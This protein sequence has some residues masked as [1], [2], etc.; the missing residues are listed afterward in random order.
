MRTITGGYNWYGFTVGILMNESTFPRPP[1]DLGNGTT[2]PFPVRLRVVKD[3]WYHGVVV[4]GDTSLLD[5]FVEGAKELESQGVKAITTNCGFLAMF[6]KQLTAAVTVPVFTSSL[7]MVPMIYRMLNPKQKVG[8][9]TVNSEALGEVHYN[10]CGWSSQEIPIVVQGLEGEK[11]FTSCFRDDLQQI[12]MD[13]MEADMV[14]AA[15]TL[16]KRAPEVGALVFECT[17]MAPYGRA[18]QQAIGGL[19]IFDIQT[20]V[21]FIYDAHHQ[22]QYS[23]HM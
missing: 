11:T 8:I 15:R 13:E 21:R 17:N 1:G 2:F 14:N 7:L 23:G 4:A 3:A 18:V 9:L 5:K 20:L 10:G 19:P 12:D 16:M 22:Q 6:Q